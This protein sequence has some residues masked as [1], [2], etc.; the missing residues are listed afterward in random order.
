MDNYLQ[1]ASRI[2]E[3]REICNYSEE[4]VCK[5]IDLDISIYKQYE[6]NGKN[7]PISVMYDLANL[8]GVDFTEILTGDSPKLDSYC[9]VKKGK[10]I[11]I[12][13]YEGYTFEGIAYKFINKKMEPMIV[14]VEKNDD[15]PDLVCH[16]GQE[17][18]Y[19]L[20]G[21]IEV[22]FGDR[23]VELNEGDCIYFDPTR[24]HGQIA[25]SPVARFLTIICE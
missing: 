13:R 20:E 9:V 22:V 24:P 18:N 11:N 1:I 10:G 15:S 6:Q 2:R 5:K 3:L 17:M 16:N 25:K 8:F 19:V 21:T 12:D 14:T 23:K 4:E 7:I